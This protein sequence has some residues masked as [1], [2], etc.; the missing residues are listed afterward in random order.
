MAG[1]TTVKTTVGM[2]SEARPGMTCVGVA[3]A[4][5]NLQTIADGTPEPFRGAV[6]QTLADALYLQRRVKR[7]LDCAERAGVV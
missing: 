3:S 2:S 1:K 7:L 5:S 4:L 6:V